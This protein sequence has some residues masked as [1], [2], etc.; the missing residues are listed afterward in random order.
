[1]IRKFAFLII[2]MITASCGAEIQEEIEETYEDGS[3]QIIKL[4]E[5]DGDERKLTKEIGY[6]PNG[7]KRIEGEFEDGKRHGKWYYWYENGNMWS[8]GSFK[9]GRRD[10]P[11]I[12]YHENGEKYVVGTYDNDQRINIWRFYD[13]NGELL[14][15]IDYNKD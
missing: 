3:P 11:G 9:N 4:Y 7:Q 6:Y 5:I 14:K 2:L 10:G 12:T 8:E 15:E 13:E 1:M